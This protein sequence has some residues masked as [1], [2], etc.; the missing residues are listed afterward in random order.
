MEPIL[1]YGIPQGCSFGSIV[2]L[3]WLGEPY[4]LCRID[5]MT[6]LGGAYGRIHPARKTPA[7]MLEDGRIVT[8]SAAILLNIAARGEG[9]KLGFAPGSADFDR[10]N[11]ALSFLTTTFF[12]SFGPLWRAYKQQDGA[13][14]R[15]LLQNV[16]ADDVAKAHQQLD[17]MLEGREWLAGPHKTVA[18]AYFAGIG[19]WANY[20][21][22]VDQRAF[23]N[24]WR[25]IEALDHDPA[26]IFARAIEAGEPAMSAGGFRG[27]VP[28]AD[29]LP[30]LAA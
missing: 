1:F 17:A 29:V 5:M 3:E 11:Q 9:R 19:R 14:T 24:V 6:E 8:E 13:E 7:L 28:L 12:A 21:R 23:P 26:V 27:H 20:H 4:R 15:Q 10:L 22:I 18:D 2:A 25:L 16:G 30:K